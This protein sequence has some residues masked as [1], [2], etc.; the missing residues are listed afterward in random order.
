M[1]CCCR[2]G[3]L[4]SDKRQQLNQL[5]SLNR[6]VM[7]AYLLKKAWNGWG[8]TLRG[9]NASLPEDLDPSFASITCLPSRSFLGH[10]KGQ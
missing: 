9:R 8:P 4:N 5:F 3:H 2:A 7:K 6:K 10:I 1:V